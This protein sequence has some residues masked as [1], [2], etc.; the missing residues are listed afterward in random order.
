MDSKNINADEFTEFVE[1]FALE[2]NNALMGILGA[3]NHIRMSV[4]P[5]SHLTEYSI[6]IEKDAERVASL[7]ESLLAFTREPAEESPG[8]II[9]LHALIRDAIEVISQTGEK[10]IDI[11]TQLEARPDSTRGNLAQIHQA[12][13]N[14]LINAAESIKTGGKLTI[15]T[16]NITVNSAFLEKHPDAEDER[17]IRLTIGGTGS[18]ISRRE[19]ENIFESIEITMETGIEVGSGLPLAYRLIKKHSG[20]LDVE[21]VFGEGRGFA[22][23]FPE[24]IPC[25][26]E[27]PPSTALLG[28]SETILIVD[29]EQHVRTVLRALLSHLGYKVLLA[30]DGAEAVETVRSYG[31]RIDLIILDVAMSGLGGFEAFH[32]I[33]KIQPDVKVIISSGYARE[34]TIS[35]LMRQGAKAFL[36]KPY[37]IHTVA[38]VIRHTLDKREA[39]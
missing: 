9:S 37:H 26:E 10:N 30:S 24:E 15:Q 2:C 6:I 7:T 17:Y 29:D 27:A 34:D 19:F 39:Q 21:S 13:L 1:K 11:E 33:L 25:V 23:Y 31:D 22:V 35:A 8:K 14:L 28:G 20:F 32:T 5:E 4:P 16:E 18:S 36:Q 38:N 12:I 3:A